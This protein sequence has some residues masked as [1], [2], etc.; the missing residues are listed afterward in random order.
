M[1]AYLAEIL[2]LTFTGFA[3]VYPLLLWLTPRKLIDGGFYRF[4]Q[5]MVSIV[6]ALGVLFYFLSN[7]DQAHLIKGLIWIVVQLFITAIYWNSKRINNFVIS[8]P[9]IIGILFLVIMRSII[10]YNISI[11]NYFIIIIGHLLAQHF[12]Q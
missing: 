11:I 9:S 10:P 12:L 1:S 5:G 3:A 4:N 8:I 2:A 7:A 6:G